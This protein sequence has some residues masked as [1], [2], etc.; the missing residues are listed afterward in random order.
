M[1]N[2]CMENTKRGELFRLRTLRRTTVLK[3]LVAGLMTVGIGAA[4]YSYTSWKQ[5]I[6]P[7]LPQDLISSV[8]YPVYYP[9]HI[10]RGYHFKVDSIANHNGLL[11][12][13]FINGNRVITVTQQATPAQKVDLNKLE[14]YSELQL[15]IGRA[16]TGQSVGNPSVIILTDSTLVNITSNKDVTKDQVLT[17]AKNMKLVEE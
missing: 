5:T 15:T 16:A 6:P 4:I 17:V 10:P 12:Y 3:I 8:G 7:P 11:F 1:L 2:S 9:S 14:G 13:K